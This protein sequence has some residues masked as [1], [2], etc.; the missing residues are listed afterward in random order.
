MRAHHAGKSLKRLAPDTQDPLSYRFISRA[1]QP[2]RRPHLHY[3]QHKKSR[4]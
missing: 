4:N 1:L 2:R 3:H